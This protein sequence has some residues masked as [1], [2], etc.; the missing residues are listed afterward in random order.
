MLFLVAL[1]CTLL[2]KL[3]SFVRNAAGNVTRALR[4]QVVSHNA[5]ETNKF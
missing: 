5:R 1:R 3:R 4:E 2:A